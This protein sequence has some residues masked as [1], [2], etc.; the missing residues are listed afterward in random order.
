MEITPQDKADLWLAVPIALAL[1]M[2]FWALQKSGLLSVVQAGS[3][4]FGAAFAIGLV[5]SLSMCTAVVGGLVL[6]M[7]A[8][9]VKDGRGGARAQAFFHVGRL[10][11]FFVLGG[12]L[13][14]LGMA[15]TLSAWMS[16]LLGIAISLVMLGLGL[17]LLGIF[18]WAERLVP[19]MPEWLAD[20]ARGASTVSHWLAPF[21]FG[22]ATFFLP[23]GFTQS[24]QVYALG[25]GSFM[26][27]GLAMLAFS[28]GTL[29]V[30]DL[31]SVGSA[32]AGGWQRKGVFFKAAGLLVIVLAVT[33]LAYSLT[34][35][36]LWPS[37]SNGGTERAQ[38]RATS[39]NISLENGI[40]VVSI[41]AEG[42]YQPRRSVAQAGLPTVIRFITRG[43]F[44]CSSSVRI[45]SLSVSRQLAQTGSTD[46]DIGTPQPG[47]YK[48]T[49]GMGMYPFEVE[50]K[51]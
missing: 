23:C 11:S 35:A 47:A 13:G 33:N 31:A 2:V 40:Q 42:G 38:G 45:P 41:R 32:R 26:A 29:P 37:E 24:M 3:V 5:A 16:S 6:S 20:R 4:S 27:G 14:A 17:N 49:C 28:L 12:A 18:P 25:T 8:T 19:S 39:S 9:F 21:F 48:G 1:G 43:S 36:G 10:A 44:D 7:T 50:F 34:A 22:A 30:L 46:I 15:F 51:S